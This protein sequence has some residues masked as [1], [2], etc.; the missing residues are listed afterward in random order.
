MSLYTQVGEDDM[1]MGLWR[2]RAIHPNTR[3]SLSLLQLGYL[4]KAQVGGGHMWG[5]WVGFITVLN[6]MHV[7]GD[8]I[9]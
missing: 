6:C 3:I 4:D 2:R 1:M 9:L 5:F 8:A 7:T